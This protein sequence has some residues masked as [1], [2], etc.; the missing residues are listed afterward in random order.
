[1]DHRFSSAGLQA[2]YISVGLLTLL[3]ASDAHAAAEGERCGRAGSWSASCDP[4][5]ECDVRWSWLRWRVGVCVAAQTGCGARLGDT[6]A[7]DEFCSFTPEATCGFAD[8]TGVCAARPE[9]CTDQYQPVCGCDGN[10][11]G[12]ACT[13]NAAGASVQS[14]GACSECQ[15]DDDCPY[16]YCDIGVT[17]AAIGCPPPPPNRCTVCGDGS[18][19]L[20]RRA[21][22][23]CPAGLVPEIVN[24]CF[25]ACV[26][27]YTCEP[28]GGT[29]EYDGATYAVG[30]TFKSSDGCNDCGCNAD[31]AVYCTLKLC[32][33]DF[34]DPTVTWVSKDP[35]EC[36][37]IDYRCDP[38]LQPFTNTCGCGCEPAA[39]P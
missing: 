13:A 28:P 22:P 12:N 38:G 26:D 29:C 16:G 36:T 17:C 30:D 7:V 20:C 23:V 24:S 4:G 25:G 1:M 31:G 9:A 37:R 33:C 27:R 15:S 39:A 8:A 6:C 5:L 21:V 10:T 11:Y 3:A 14:D 2:C 34:T 19:L 35:E 18:Q 32:V